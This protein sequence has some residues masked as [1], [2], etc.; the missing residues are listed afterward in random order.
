MYSQES[1][2][3]RPG[4]KGAEAGFITEPVTT[5]GEPVT[6]TGNP[7]HSLCKL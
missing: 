6:T 3:E 1:R 5:T 4:R 7:A 2:E